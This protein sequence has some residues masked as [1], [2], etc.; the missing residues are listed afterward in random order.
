MIAYIKEPQYDGMDAVT[1]R[2][3]ARVDAEVIFDRRGYKPINLNIP[4]KFTTNGFK[5]IKW[6]LDSNRAWKQALSKLTEKD[7][8]ILQYPCT[9]FNLLLPRVLKSARTK[10]VLLIHDWERFRH[11]ENKDEGL[12]RRIK[13]RIEEKLLKEADKIIVHNDMMKQ[14]M[15]DYG[16][17]PNKL[18][19]LG[20]FDYLIDNID[21]A[22]IEQRNNSKD[23]PI[24]I[25]GNLT[26]KKSGY[27]YDLPKKTK[28]N[29][30]GAGYEAEKKETIY[31]RG[32]FPPDD[33]PYHMDGS[34]GLVWDGPTSETCAG[35]TGNYLRINNPHKTSLYLASE[36][37]VI[38]WSKAALA[39]FIRD[40]RCGITVDSL[41]QINS[42]IEGLSDNDYKDMQRNAADIATQLR[43]G[44]SL[45]RALNTVEEAIV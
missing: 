23:M 15:E 7:I 29:L 38:I 12:G 20:I 41:A 13:C 9:D 18:V 4:S 1:A 39:T 32:P 40:H 44:A 11:V 14:K 34:F 36:I 10:I 5:R 25:A 27:I 16:I 33:L 37:P 24:I 22:K 42:A 28:F 45:D 8:L 21:R 17:E 43:T 3:K 26:R 19:S 6:H 2:S 31:Y 35:A 30:F